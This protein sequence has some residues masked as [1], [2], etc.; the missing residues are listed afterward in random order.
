MKTSCV[1]HWDLVSSSCCGVVQYGNSGDGS[2]DQMV[3]RY[4]KRDELL[5][6]GSQNLGRTV[7]A[8]VTKQSLSGGDIVLK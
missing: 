6:V 3:N 5:I 4:S 1:R 2:S 8:G 7:I